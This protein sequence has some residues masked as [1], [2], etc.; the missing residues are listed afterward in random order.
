MSEVTQRT[1]TWTAKQAVEFS[2]QSDS[3]INLCDSSEKLMA[4]LYPFSPRILKLHTWDGLKGL[5]A[6]LAKVPEFE[7]NPGL[8]VLDD[9]PSG[10]VF[11]IW[12]DV[13]K[14]NA[15][16][17]TAIEV[18]VTPAQIPQLGNAFERILEY[19]EDRIEPDPTLQER[20][21]P[22]ASKKGFKKP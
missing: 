6:P 1:G 7:S 9:A 11:M 5:G 19:I 2:K 4:L 16:K 13:F 20:L 8:W 21:V 14:K 12:S 10:I 15:W 18:V 22:T 17:G 3:L